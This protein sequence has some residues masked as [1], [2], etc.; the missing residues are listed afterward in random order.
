MGV[1]R[2]RDDG[3]MTDMTCC[4]LFGGVAGGGRRCS[5]AP[6]EG[7]RPRR[8]ADPTE[9]E[10]GRRE[11]GAICDAVGARQHHG[12]MCVDIDALPR[13]MCGRSRGPSERAHVSADHERA[14]PPM[15]DTPVALFFRA[16][17]QSPAFARRHVLPAHCSPPRFKV[18]TFRALGYQSASSSRPR[19]ACCAGN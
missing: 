14:R 12:A 19:P 18:L 4:A 7:R 13:T 11:E 9:R 16:R 5:P 6:N 8:A 15:P 3:E 1:C 17:A 2:G 10:G